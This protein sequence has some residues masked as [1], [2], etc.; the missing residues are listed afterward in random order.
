MYSYISVYTIEILIFHGRISWGCIEGRWFSHP[1]I[2]S[3]SMMRGILMH[4]Q[5]TRDFFKHLM[6]IAWKRESASLW[7]AWR[8]RNTV[9]L[10]TFTDS[11]SACLC[12]DECLKT[13]PTKLAEG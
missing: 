12:L 10:I 9:A 6:Q 1:L 4:A 3:N 2:Q 13:L 5:K 11:F 8:L 7:M